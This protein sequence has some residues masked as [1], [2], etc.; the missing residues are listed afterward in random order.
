[1]S[2]SEAGPEVNAYLREVRG[3]LGDLP[4]AEVDDITRELES[5][6]WDSLGKGHPP[7]PLRKILTRL[8]PSKDLASRYRASRA[9]SRAAVSPTPVRVLIAA[10]AWTRVSVHGVWVLAVAVAGYFLSASFLAAAVLKPIF[11]D[12]TGLW[13]LPD[14]D[15]YSLRLGLKAGPP[16]GEEILGWAMI[17]VGLALGLV[18]FWTVTQYARSVL[19]K[20]RWHPASPQHLTDP[21]L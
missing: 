10:F 5:H 15:S 18:L 3:H 7:R 6:I 12:R 20:A 13:R 21:P 19:A 8:G 11:P 1:M 9:A 2:N 4:D 16:A 14:G 17:P